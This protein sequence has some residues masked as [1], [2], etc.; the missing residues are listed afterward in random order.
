[1][2]YEE[3][4]EAVSYSLYPFLLS[5]SALHTGIAMGTLDT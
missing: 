3:N 1:M 2:I 4:H 5:A